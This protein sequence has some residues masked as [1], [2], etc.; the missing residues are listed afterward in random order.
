MSLSMFA[1]T[2]GDESK[3]SRVG[4]SEHDDCSKDKHDLT[5]FL[6]DP[7]GVNKLI[8]KVAPSVS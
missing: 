5:F 8:A 1:G 6:T 4:G 7:K 2:G 3:W